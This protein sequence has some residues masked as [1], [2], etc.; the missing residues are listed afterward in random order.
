[1]L[2]SKLQVVNQ[3][4]EDGFLAG[5]G[6][7]TLR[8]ADELRDEGDVTKLQGEVII[9]IGAMEIGAAFVGIACSIIEAFYVV[10]I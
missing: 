5:R 1:M 7:V 9:G 6:V 10:N 8:Y 4:L 3:H 2:H